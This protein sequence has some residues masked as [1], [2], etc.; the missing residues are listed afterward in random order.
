[1]DRFPKFL[2]QYKQAKILLAGENFG[3]GSSRE[4]ASWALFEYGFRAVVAVSFADIFKNNALKNGLLPIA[5]DRSAIDAITAAI[6]TN[7]AT[8]IQI[9]LAAQTIAWPGETRSFYI[10]PFSKKCL[11][12]G[13]DD[14]GYTLSF[15]KDIAAYEKLHNIFKIV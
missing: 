4:H 7:P 5:L 3:C 14:I 15:E 12:M 10:N 8:Q 13:L 11:L 1:M 9:D 6:T 2:S